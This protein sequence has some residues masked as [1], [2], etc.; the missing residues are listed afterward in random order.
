[1]RIAV[2]FIVMIGCTV[3][4]NLLMKMGAAP[5]PSERLLFGLLSWKLVAGVTAF[6]CA[7]LVYAWL[8]HWLPL[9][10]AQ[11][12]AAI[13]FVA[14]IFASSAVLAERIPPLRWLGIA[15]IVGGVI[16]VGATTTG[17]QSSRRIDPSA[18]A[19]R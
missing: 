7:A 18:A 6:G 10:V 17:A 14:V 2:G 3:T 19:G 4:A 16:L 9:N 1:M 5:P 8:L 11:S 15:L 13:Q 12:F